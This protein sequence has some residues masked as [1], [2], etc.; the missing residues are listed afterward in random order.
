M[1]DA[2]QL[3]GDQVKALLDLREGYLL[4]IS[5]IMKH[6]WEISTSLSQAVDP[7]QEV[8]IRQANV[9]GAHARVSLP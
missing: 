1:Q 9:M 5:T 4:K 6:R 7:V 8:E 2:M 3:T